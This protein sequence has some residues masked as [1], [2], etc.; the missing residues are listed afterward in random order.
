MKEQNPQD[1]S[2]KPAKWTVER[3]RS[4]GAVT[5]V[6][7]AGAALGIGRTKAHEL[8]KMKQFPVRIIKVGSRYLVPVADL[9]DLLVGEAAP[10]HSS[11]EESRASP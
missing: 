9:I 7:T 6:V 11:A 10:D 5:N 1:E 8:A 2:M 4:L 3:V